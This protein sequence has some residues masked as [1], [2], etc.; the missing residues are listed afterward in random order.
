MFGGEGWCVCP[1]G[2]VC[3]SGLGGGG[4]GGLYVV[5]EGGVLDAMVS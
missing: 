4:G 3:R 1:L 5:V 2:G